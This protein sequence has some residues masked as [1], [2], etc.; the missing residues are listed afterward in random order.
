MNSMG[1]CGWAKVTATI[2]LSQKGQII[3]VRFSGTW[4]K[5]CAEELVNDYLPFIKQMKTGKFGVLAD[6]KQF[7]G[8][9]PDAI[10]ALIK[11]SLWSS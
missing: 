1:L 2:A 9:T 11:L 7:E 5:E 4:N 3:I 6:L 8:A 10:K